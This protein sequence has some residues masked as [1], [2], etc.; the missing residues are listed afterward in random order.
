[1]VA[2]T[3]YGIPAMLLLG[4]GFVVYV[5]AT[6][7]STPDRSGGLKSFAKGEM[8]GLIFD[9]DAPM[10][11]A[12]TLLGPEGEMRLADIDAHFLVVNFWATNCPPCIIEMPTLAA[13]QDNYPK[14][15][16]QVIPVS[17]DR[18][19]DHPKARKL[20]DKLT[21]QRLP[22]YADPK[23]ASLFDARARGFP[24]TII[25]DRKGQELARYE[26]ETDW[27]GETAFALFDALI[28]ETRD[29]DTPES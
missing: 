14:N 3:R 27:G 22:F 18:A 6:A 17:L 29:T 4:L 26:G 8:S 11:P 23:M 15:E 10:R 12:S 9:P 20:L 5:W 24:T 7:S 21:G 16:L 28:A 19:G 25:Y 13:L 2:L 1:M